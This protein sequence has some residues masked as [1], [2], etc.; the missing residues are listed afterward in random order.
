MTKNNP[1][2]Y[3]QGPSSFGSIG[4]IGNIPNLFTVL[5]LIFGCIA[6]VFILQTG[7]TIVVMDNLGATQVFLPERIWWGSLFI[8]GAAIIDFL[9]GFLARAMK[10]TSEMGKQL[11]SLS[12]V[13]S[14]GVAPGMI[15]YQLLR[16]SYAQQEYGLDVSFMALVPA[17]IFSGAVAWRL[18]KFNIATNQ[19][20]NFRGVPSPAA[21]LVV[22]SFPLIILHEYFGLHTLFINEWVLYGIIIVLS[23]LMVCDRSFMALK[24]KDYSVQN[25]LT[26]Y[27]LVVAA[28]ICALFLKWLAVP[29][30]FILY[31]I[32]SIF[33][34]EPHRL[35]QQET[36]DI[37]D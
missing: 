14:F 29:V 26:K 21:G 12:D 6:I 1:N 17:F 32:L 37:L 8:F 5:N 35:E 27:I 20:Y 9:D 19:T 33:T 30:I 22:A 4:L 11:D 36:K 34:K 16:I 3:M 28:I 15:L 25:N 10:A 31:C 13:V 2:S 23:Y 18:A 7:E 24:F